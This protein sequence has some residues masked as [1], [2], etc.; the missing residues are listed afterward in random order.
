MQLSRSRIRLP[1]RRRRRRQSFGSGGRRG[2]GG[3]S[4]CVGE[5]EGR[6]DDLVDD[7]GE[8]Q[9]DSVG[10]GGP[11]GGFSRYSS[12]ALLSSAPVLLLLEGCG[13]RTGLL[14]LEVGLPEKKGSAPCVLLLPC[15][16]AW[17]LLPPAR[18]AHLYYE[19]V[20]VPDVFILLRTKYNVST[21]ISLNSFLDEQHKYVF[22]GSLVCCG[23][24]ERE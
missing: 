13:S 24:R 21:P 17:L 19:I 6:V 8:V 23:E 4:G 14:S 3:G 7:E 20:R 5:G 11:G 22:V 9:V 1:S 2:G 18:A 12:V 16:P 10:G 15:L